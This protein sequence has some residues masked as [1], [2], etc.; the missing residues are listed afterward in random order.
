MALRQGLQK[1]GHI[2]PTQGLVSLCGLW[3]RVDRVG[4]MTGS[5]GSSIGVICL[6]SSVRQMKGSC[7]L[8]CG[9]KPQAL[10]SMLAL[11][12]EKPACKPQICPFLAISPWVRHLSSFVKWRFYVDGENACEHIWCR[13]CNM[14]PWLLLLKMPVVTPC[15]LAMQGM[16]ETSLLEGMEAGALTLR[17]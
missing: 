10:G 7:V 17:L 8:G 5:P 6:A 2:S 14:S 9:F 13:V 4:K 16:P 11:A 15:I 3:V 12:S 1:K